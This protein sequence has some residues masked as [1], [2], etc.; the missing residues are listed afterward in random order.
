MTKQQRSTLAGLARRLGYK[1]QDS[2]SE[3]ICQNGCRF[4]N[5]QHAVLHL[6]NP[7]GRV[8]YYGGNGG[9]AEFATYD[10]AVVFLTARLLGAECSS[11]LQKE[12]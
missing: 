9:H 12:E 1:K 11:L 10:D 8:R 3:L 4:V 2:H 6:P 5:S 7:S